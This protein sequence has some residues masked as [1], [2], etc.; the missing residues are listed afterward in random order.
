MS[1]QHQH[2][3]ADS[4]GQTGPDGAMGG[5]YGDPGEAESLVGQPVEETGADEN[6]PAE[7]E[8]PQEP[9]DR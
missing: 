2:T 7:G 8:A 5:D 6:E 4:D 3:P 1:D 9:T